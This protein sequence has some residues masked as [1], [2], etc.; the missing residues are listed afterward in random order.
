M[1]YEPSLSIQP[2]FRLYHSNCVTAIT[3]LGQALEAAL[4]ELHVGDKHGG[5]KEY[6][7]AVRNL[8][9]NL[10]VSGWFDE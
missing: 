3:A 9:A 8:T 4:F 1:P 2:H 6:K 5:A 10:R 7:T